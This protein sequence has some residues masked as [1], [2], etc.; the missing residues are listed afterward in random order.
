MPA[1]RHV[2][3]LIEA[4]HAYARGLL[5][6]VAQYTH[7]RGHWTVYF[8]LH[9]LEDP[10]PKWLKNWKGDGMLARI[11]SRRMARAVLD[12]GLPLVEP[13]RILTIPGVPVI[14]PDHEAVARLAAEH[15]RERGFRHFGVCGVPRG[16]DPPLDHRVDAFVQ[17]LKQADL[18]CSVFPAPRGASLSQQHSSIARWI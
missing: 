3:L 11:G 6:G 5:H 18:P 8:E 15:L 17:H 9:S 4:T 10:P 12:A 7:E 14:G 1:T 16:T 13:R 2:A